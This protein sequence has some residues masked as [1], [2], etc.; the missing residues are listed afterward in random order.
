MNLRPATVPPTPHGAFRV[1]RGLVAIGALAAA[2]FAAVTT[3]LVET[4]DL[5]QALT[6]LSD[7]LG[8][9]RGR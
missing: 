7:T 4:P 1:P 6:D 3:G 2:A 5:E 8:A 9:W